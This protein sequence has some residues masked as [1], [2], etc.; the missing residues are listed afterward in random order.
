MNAQIFETSIKSEEEASY[1]L[2]LLRKNISDALI[3]FNFKPGYSIL[4]VK[5]NREIAGIVYSLCNRQ[6]VYCQQL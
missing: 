3:Q 4:T 5:S 6:G 2:S 1:L